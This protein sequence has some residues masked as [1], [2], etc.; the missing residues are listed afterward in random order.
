[1]PTATLK[2][3]A[4]K[5]LRNFTPNDVTY[6]HDKPSAIDTKHLVVSFIVPASTPIVDLT[7]DVPGI[8]TGIQT[9]NLLY[10]DPNWIG[11]HIEVW[12]KEVIKY[13]SPTVYTGYN[14]LVSTF[15]F[16]A[17]ILADKSGKDMFVRVVGHYYNGASIKHLSALEMIV[18]YE[19]TAEMIMSELKTDWNSS[20]F[21][22]FNDLNRVESA[23]EII[24]NQIKELRYI[25]L[26]LS[27]VK[28]RTV[29]SFVF[30]EN[31]NRIENNILLLKDAFPVEIPFERSKVTWQYNDPFDYSDANRLEKDLSKLYQHFKANILKFPYPGQF[32]TGQEGVF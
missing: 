12:E 16:N 17:T 32:T 3:K 22:N 28:D 1:M 31:L 26:S 8:L 27:L 4:I 14:N 6:L 30:A 18:N 21:Y 23:T 15:T 2:P 19:K 7:F 11:L 5:F 29:K 10:V 20:D 25:N 24:A 13:T 9:V